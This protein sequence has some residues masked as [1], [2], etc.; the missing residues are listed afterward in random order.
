MGDE[1]NTGDWGSLPGALLIATLLG[2]LWIAIPDP[3]SSRPSSDTDKDE[4][5]VVNNKARSRLWQDPFR[6][7]NLH[8]KR[9]SQA[10]SYKSPE[11][12][13]HAVRESLEK[14][15]QGADTDERI[16]V[17]MVMVSGGPYAE[18]H[19]SRL[20]QRY[21][22]QAGMG[23]MGFAPRDRGHVHY[24]MWEK[25]PPEPRRAPLP[26]PY[27]WFDRGSLVPAHGVANNVAASLVL[28][29]AEDA[30]ANEPLK[31]IASLRR[32]VT[33]NSRGHDDKV[34]FKVLG[35]RNSNTLG[36]MLEEL[37]AFGESGRASVVGEQWTTK[38]LRGVEFINSFSTATDPL[39]VP[40]VRGVPVGRSHTVTQFEKYG[41][42][43]V[44]VSATDDQLVDQL[45][46]ELQLRRALPENHNNEDDD[47]HI[48]L[49][50]EWDTLYGRA[51]PLTFA[52]KLESAHNHTEY[53]DTLRR[54]KTGASNW[55][56][57]IHTFSYLRGVDGNVPAPA[58][59]SGDSGDSKDGS[60]SGNPSRGRKTQTRG[61][62][63]GQLD[64]MRRLARR[65]WDEDR[66]LRNEG[67]SGFRAIG[68]LGSDV[69][70]KLIVLQALRPLFPGKPFFTTDLDVRLLDRGEQKWTR[71]LVV[72]SGY[73]LK[74]RHDLQDPV[75]PFRNSYQ[76]AQYLACLKALGHRELSRLSSNP[77]PR[78][79]EVGARGA[80]DLTVPK[81]ALFS[82]RD[83][84][85]LRGFAEAVKQH[86]TSNKNSVFSDLNAQLTRNPELK[87]NDAEL[88]KD[89]ARGLNEI[90]RQPTLID[91]NLFGR[92]APNSLTGEY[93][94]RFQGQR[95]IGESDRELTF[96]LNRRLIVDAYPTNLL[97]G[98]PVHPIK[99]RFEWTGKSIA[100]LVVLLVIPLAS[101]E[102]YAWRGQ[103]FFRPILAKQRANRAKQLEQE[104]AVAKERAKNPADAAT[105]WPHKL[106]R[107]E[108]SLRKYLFWGLV[109]APFVVVPAIILI[110]GMPKEEP[111][112][113]V[114]GVSSWPTEL[115]RLAVVYV[116]FILIART[117]SKMIR[118]KHHVS[119]HFIPGSPPRIATFSENWRCYEEAEELQG[120]K[121][122]KTSADNPP[123]PAVGS[124]SAMRKV[125][126]VCH[127]WLTKLN[128]Y[129]ESISIRRWQE[130]LFKDRDPKDKQD[131]EAPKKVVDLWNHYNRLG[132]F[133][134]RALRFF[135]LAILYFIGSLMLFMCLGFPERPIRG[136]W[137]HAFDWV[138]LV[139]SV[140]M[141]ILL[142]FFVLDA[143]RLCR[144]FVD[145][146]TKSDLD[147]PVKE[148]ARDSI[149]K[150][151]P[152]WTAFRFLTAR[153]KTVNGLIYYPF[154]TLAMSIVARNSF[155]DAWN[156]PPALVIVLSVNSIIAASAVYLMRLSAIRAKRRI[157]RKLEAK[158]F[159]AQGGAESR[160]ETDEAGNAN[161]DSHS[162]EPQL[163]E[164]QL[165][166]VIKRIHDYHDGLFA[167]LS[168]QPVV[169]AVLMPFG[170]AGLVII[171]D[172]L[173]GG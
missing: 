142:T 45:I 157:L 53:D 23:K 66:R 96:R 41:A 57:Y 10:D 55:P 162:N 47:H 159:A 35:P 127:Q 131:D 145:I 158:L 168:Q 49:I 37:E 36:L 76:T 11:A 38:L 95:R 137:S 75:A 91:S 143:I 138:I 8:R 81:P 68:V 135:P 88:R 31:Q 80:V 92:A 94:D 1:K 109:L 155:F 98:L 170:G 160:P 117:R 104:K 58:A 4:M 125:W 139:V 167:P 103:G 33:E 39:L 46:V 22:I 73:D 152:E 59:K 19:E 132:F 67:G 102:L 134:N 165:N 166:Q 120:A 18:D 171:L 74:L 14:V 146:M 64:Y 118:N 44:N 63:T 121:T 169:R 156:W 128:Q 5:I 85:Y 130:D 30:F 51:L 100:I 83:I 84:M 24:F 56:K 61:E 89:L 60:K 34:E 97:A 144:R 107:F 27:E 40:D 150:N 28:W 15:A 3:R 163:N 119:R 12:S 90:I 147:W 29:L 141:Q 69:Y 52:A 136:D 42:S 20:R 25:K 82:A 140:L 101:F 110:S 21:A 2:G 151:S 113:F 153:T 54:L 123:T 133:W 26:V 172:M 116:A 164:K 79:F 7:V 6:A 114:S 111:F 9:K 13:I 148:G 50:T 65:L 173:A 87:P 106:E 108:N 78:T 72:A 154:I 115:M 71:N 48:A 77:A 124:P 32:L 149:A 70:D 17:L 126:N 161:D 62:G 86:A 112:S 16:V 99:Q 122:A 129:R 43:F 105:P 93:S